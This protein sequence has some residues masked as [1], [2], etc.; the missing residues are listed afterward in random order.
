MLKSRSTVLKICLSSAIALT[1]AWLLKGQPAHAGTGTIKV[2]VSS[3]HQQFNPVWE[4]LGEFEAKTGI[5]VELD[6][7][8]TGDI[9]TKALQDLR[10]GGC[11][12]DSVEIPDDA[13]ASLAQL[14]SDLGPYI[15]R[16]GTSIAEFKASQVP[17]AIKAVTFDG[18]VKYYP[19]YSGA[20]SV[21][22]R[23]DLFENPANQE[24]FK[25]QFGYTLPVPPATVQQFIDLAKFFNKDGMAGVVFSGSG[26]SAETTIADLIFRSGIDGYVDAEGNAAWGDKHPDDQAKVAAATAWLSGLIHK[27]KV[28]PG[29]VTAMDT[30]GAVSTYTAGKAAMVYD[31]IYLSWSEF[32]LPNVTSVIGKSGSFELPSF[33]AGQGGIPF[34]WARGIPACSK[35]KDAAWKFTKWVMSDENLRLALTKGVGVFVPTDIKLLDWGVGEK[36]VPEG[37]AAAVKHGKAYTVNAVTGQM[38]ANFT[39]PMIE[40]VLQGQMSPEEFAKQS[41]AGIQEL[42]DSS[43]AK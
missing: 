22:Y 1:G 39:Q 38:R 3:G 24:A 40:K 13:L 11:T 37:T 27:D 18:Q 16:D 28:A 42:M 21:A 41:G 2:L 8:S 30:G 23:R 5:H 32:Q 29:D 31:T 6:K 36:V 15:E 35:N 10:L 43:G 25:K 19:F 33:V 17:W 14:M 34:W 12:Y 26:D 9:Q 4:K 20:K 7:V